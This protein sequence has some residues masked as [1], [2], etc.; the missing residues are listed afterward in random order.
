MSRLGA[1]SA[2][3]LFRVIPGGARAGAPDGVSTISDEAIVSAVRRG[4]ARVASELCSR[5][6][7]AVDHTLYRVVG[8]RGADHDDLVQQSF[9][10]I[11]LTLTRGTFAHGCSLRTWASRVATNVGLNAVR[12]RRRER[13]V[14]DRSQSLEP[15]YDV[16]GGPDPRGRLE[17]RAELVRVREQ[18]ADMNPRQVEVLVL[19]DVL[20]H[21]LREISLML[22]KSRPAV[23]S[24]L[25]RGRCELRRRLELLG[26]GSEGGG[27]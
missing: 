15:D 5:V 14:V 22:R 9:E 27:S 4:D 10:Q 6:V 16:F 8:E 21:D 25:F 26:L 17:A 23:Q 20:G 12:S 1:V 11:V 3:T 19:H 13:S 7:D 24:R 18:L 2:R